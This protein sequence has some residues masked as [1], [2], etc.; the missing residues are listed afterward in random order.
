M[1]ISSL[2]VDLAYMAL[3]ALGDLAKLLA[4]ALIVAA[5]ADGLISAIQ[6]I[7]Q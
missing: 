7:R 1:E 3:Y 6:I 2:A 4:G 5:A